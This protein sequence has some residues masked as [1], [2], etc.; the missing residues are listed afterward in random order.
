MKSVILNLIISA[1]LSGLVFAQGEQGDAAAI[2]DLRATIAGDAAEVPVPAAAE[3]VKPPLPGSHPGYGQAITEFRSGEFRFISDARKSMDKALA[4]LQAA[5]IEVIDSELKLRTYT[6]TFVSPRPV[7]VV[8]FDS[9]EYT[10]GMDAERALDKIVEA[11]EAGGA[12]V[13]ECNMNAMRAFRVQ[14]IETRA[15]GLDGG[16]RVIEFESAE[17]PFSTDA[18]KSMN[19]AVQGLTAAGYAVVESEERLGRYGITFVARGPVKFRSYVSREFDFDREAEAAMKRAAEALERG[20]AV[21]VE[22]LVQK[23]KKFSIKYFETRTSYSPFPQ[24]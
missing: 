17:F 24:Y 16:Q 21:V 5:G 9:R 12:A 14:Y 7:R 13:L 23:D 3:R 2:N 10:F 18:R 20:G 22:Q 11:L 4:G 6:I 15:H 19:K 8:A 1:S